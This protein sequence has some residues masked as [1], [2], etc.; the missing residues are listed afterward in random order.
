[1]DED[2]L[3]RQIIDQYLLAWGVIVSSTGTGPHALELAK[4]AAA[5]KSPFDAIIVDR[6]A[7]GDGIAFA[8]RLGAEPELAGTALVFISGTEERMTTHDARARGFVAVMRKPI[9]QGALHDALVEAITGPALQRAK[10]AVD[11]VL[12]ERERVL[13]LVAEDNPVNRKLAL[14]QLKRLGYRAHAVGDGREAIEAVASGEYTLVL[15]DCQ[16]P[17][18]DGFEATR[19]IRRAESTRGG[20]IPIVA[21][22]ANALEGDREACLDAGMDG[23]LAKPVQLSALRAVIEEFTTGVSIAG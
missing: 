18:V 19:E 9:R 8:A 15:M 10:P 20:H 3:A 13:V 16:M 7:G 2:P 4:A 5:K 11:A 1:V 14:Q 6:T 22:T 21:M 12:E 17:D 23:Y